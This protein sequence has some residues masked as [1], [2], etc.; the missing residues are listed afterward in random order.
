MDQHILGIDVSKLKFNVCLIRADGRPRPR[1]FAN[2]EAG[3]SEL[4]E[5]LKKNGV[6]QVHASLE[7]T[8]TYSEARAIYLSD[9]GQLVSRVNP[10][11]T[12]A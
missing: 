11:A 2:N 9:A 12:K 1:V 10:A 3:F 5:W 4:S 8:G 7:A 6:S